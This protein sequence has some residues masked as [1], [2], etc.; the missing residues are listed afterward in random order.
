MKYRNLPEMHRRQANRLGSRPALRYKRHGLYHDISWEQYRADAL[1]CAAAL[2]DAGIKPGDRVG[3][4]SENRVEWLIADMAI[5]TAGAVNVPP[6]CPLSARQIHFQF[7]DADVRWA[8]VSSVDQLAKIQHI[9]AELPNLQG[10][11]L[12]DRDDAAGQGK[13]AVLSWAWFLQ[14]G[15]QILA[16]TAPELARREAELASEHLATI[17]YTSGTT[18]NPKG[19]MLT[20]ANLVSNATASLE[21]APVL[22]DDLF[23]NW[24]PLS[25]IYARTCDHYQTL[26]AGV[27]LALA[28]SAETVVLNLAETQPT[29][30]SS[31]PRF[32]EKVLAAVVCND[33]AET[34]RKLRAIFGPR[35][36]WL[37][38][39]GAPL[40]KPIGEVFVAA[41]L[42]VYQGYGLTESSPVISFNRLGRNKL[43]TV[44]LPLPGVEIA[45]GPDGE[46]LTR[47]PHV[48][49]GYWKNP[50]ATTAAIGDG[51]LHTGDLGEIDAEGFLSITGR[52]KDLMVLSNGKKVV[53][54]EIEG[55]LLGEQC[56]D[57]AVIYGEG[58]NYLSALIVP[59]WEN[60]RRAM[61]ENGTNV[62]GQPEV[63]LAKD[64]GVQAF[65]RK[66]I[67][68]ALADMSNWEQVRKFLV[69]PQQFTVAAEELTVSL[70]LRRNVVLGKYAA[71]LEALY[72]E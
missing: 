55:L 31:V 25:H 39:G 68:V 44:G 65:L 36:K 43:G 61:Q 32:Y 22:P 40:P 3:V 42:P 63:N 53:P 49:K 13:A 6:H 20:H 1:A 8:F 69:L 30:V 62:N 2:V 15:R 26:A 11:V 37:A 46:V 10:V 52:K 59:Q 9:R 50:S 54:T 56:I 41:G 24:L 27:T 5:L 16:R 35:I 28:D 70:K 51:W 72:K 29:H 58:R 7:E 38:A 21:V 71:Q 19:V 60:L 47:G 17:M 66:R 64:P 67:D 23:L 33:R 14:H 4:L 12:F 48:M 34:A 18:G 57:Q 45:I